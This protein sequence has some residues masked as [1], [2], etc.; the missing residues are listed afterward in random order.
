MIIS[1]GGIDS[2]RLSRLNIMYKICDSSGSCKTNRNENLKEGY[3]L[4]RRWLVDW[5]E[6][7]KKK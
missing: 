7:R 3:F 4:E 2:S 6:D 1:D 5:T